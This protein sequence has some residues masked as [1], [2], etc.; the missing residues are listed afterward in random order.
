M[1]YSIKQDALGEEEPFPEFQNCPLVEKI[2]VMFCFTSKIW[3]PERTKSQ[4]RSYCELL[5]LK[6][7]LCCDPI[8]E[9]HW[10]S[11]E[12]HFEQIREF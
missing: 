1:M 5:N 6:Q 9:D 2:P 11:V 3:V 4:E 7:N 8:L 10:P 12:H